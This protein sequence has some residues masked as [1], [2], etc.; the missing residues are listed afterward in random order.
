MTP[1]G[2]RR[3]ILAGAWVGVAICATLPLA[4][5]RGSA[6]AL[7][8]CDE[9]EAFMRK[10][11]LTV[12]KAPSAIMD[13]GR[14]NHRVFVHT[15]DE[16]R[17]QF[18]DRDTWKANLAAYE[19]ARMLQ[20]NIMPP[21][22]EAKVNGQPGSVSWGLENVMM[23]EGQRTQR[24]VQPP[25]LDAWNTQMYVV[26]VFEE[27]VTNKRAPNDLVITKDWRAWLLAPSQAFRPTKTIQN[28]DNLVKCDRKL[29]TRMR[30]LDRNVLKGRLGKWLLE[31]E[32]DALDA[33]AG[34][35]VQIFEDQIAARG[36]A[37]VL[38]DFDRSGPLCGL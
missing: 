34:A 15:K 2:R 26:Q 20:I 30:A 12:M 25:D 27:L 7:R 32:I 37:A 36:E 29:L 22:V 10:A 38:F 24:N 19:L 28:R 1:V 9:I 11:V 13:D 17:T 14:T 21:Y 3:H 18:P 16:S 35:I 6:Q 23:D 4:T 31:D 5:Q 33:R 8:T